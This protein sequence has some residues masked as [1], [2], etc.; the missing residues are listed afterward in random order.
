[1]IP[2]EKV[3]QIMHHITQSCKKHFQDTKSNLR[4]H[5]MDLASHLNKWSFT[6]LSQVL[7]YLRL[8]FDG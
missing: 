7:L 6:Q 4:P 5:Q 8:F 1:L 2:L 3:F